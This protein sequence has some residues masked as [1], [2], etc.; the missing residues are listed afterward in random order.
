MSTG[1]LRQE[2]RKHPRASRASEVVVFEWETADGAAAATRGTLGDVSLGG[3]AVHT[4]QEMPRIG[5]EGTVTIYFEVV[6]VTCPAVLIRRWDGGMAL[7]F[8]D[9][10]PCGPMGL[11]VPR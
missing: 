8:V 1:G 4:G 11:D 7:A 5:A 2:R 6:Q 3:I 9:A 10:A